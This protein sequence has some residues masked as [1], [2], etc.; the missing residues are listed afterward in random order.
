MRRLWRGEARQVLGDV[1]GVLQD[2]R[3]RSPDLVR[4]AGGE[5]AERD[6]AVGRGYMLQKAVV[7]QRQAR[8]CGENGGAV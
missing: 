3:E 8:L 6:E 2:V 5:L 1:A 7:F 4:N